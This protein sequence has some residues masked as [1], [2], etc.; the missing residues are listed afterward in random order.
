[1]NELLAAI[2]QDEVIL[3]HILAVGLGI[4]R[5]VAMLSFAPFFGPAVTMPMRM[6]LAI[7]LYMPLHPYF[8]YCIDE[9]SLIHTFSINVL[10]LLALKETILGM[11]LAMITGFVF[12]ATMSAG[13]IVDNQR[14]ASQAQGSEIMTGDEISPFGEVLFLSMLTLF[15]ASGAFVAFL[16]LFYKSY[17]L[18]PVFNFM[19]SLSS[20]NIALF[21]ADGVDGLMTTALLLCGPFMLVSL[22]TDIS[23]G[24]INRFAPQLNVYILSMPIKSG[25]CALLI[26]FFVLPYFDISAL[27]LEKSHDMSQYF[28]NLVRGVI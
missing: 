10:A 12:W 4:T 17:I 7:A 26:V 9:Q 21:F 16:M 25:L 6:G 15:Y 5:V 22:M 11:L 18:W 23:L 1:M 8:V 20:S 2:T 3:A 27:L 13:F 24:I 14:G 19:P 28:L